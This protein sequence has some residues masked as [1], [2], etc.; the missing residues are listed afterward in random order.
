MTVDQINSLKSDTRVT[1]ERRVHYIRSPEGLLL[2]ALRNRSLEHAAAGLVAQWDDD[3][4]HH[5]DRI[6]RQVDDYDVSDRHSTLL[7]SWMVLDRT[8]GKLYKSFTRRE[9]WEGSV[10]MNREA[11]LRIRYPDDLSKAEDRA[12]MGRF[13]RRYGSSLMEAHELYT[14]CYHGDNTWNSAHWEFIFGKCTEVTGEE[15]QRHLEM[16]GT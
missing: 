15:K 13:Q 14:Y 11:A 6:A 5:P 16:M 1:E 4:W 2:G 9:G 12:F 3:D 8:T 7:S 10:L